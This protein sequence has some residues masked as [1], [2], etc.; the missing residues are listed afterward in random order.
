MSAPPPK[1]MIAR[2][3]A[4]PRP[5]GEPFH[6]RRDRRD[7][8]E[9]QPDPADHAVAQV[10]DARACAAGPPARRPASRR[11]SSSAGRT[12][13]SAARPARPTG[14]KRRGEPEHDERDA[15]RSS[16]P[17]GS[18][19]PPAIDCAIADDAGQRPVED[20]ESV[21]LADAEVHRQRGGRDQPTIEAG[22]GDDP[23]SAKKS[24]KRSSHGDLPKRQGP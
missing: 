18:S 22:P 1:P 10:D 17:A 19:S 14:R 16:R 24:R 23:L 11:R 9:A 21:D 8:A 13:S 15:S 12:S 5:V 2:P 6:Q 3:V 7:V 20:A 4:M